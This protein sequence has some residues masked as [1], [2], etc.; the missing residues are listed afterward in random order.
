M[1]INRFSMIKR[2]L[3]LSIAAL[4]IA[5]GQERFTFYYE[6]DGTFVKPLYRTD[7]HYTDGAKFEFT[8]QPDVNF[9]KE[10]SK[11]DR[12][13]LNDGQV[14][15]AL[16]YFLGQNIYTP[17][18]TENPAERSD[19]DMK[20]AGW[21]YGGIFAQRQSDNRMEHLELNLGMIGPAASGES[22]QKFIHDI[23]HTDAPEGWESQLDNE[24][25]ADL[26][27][28]RRQRIPEL[29]KRTECLDTHLEYGGTLGTLHRN[30]QLGIV[31]RYGMNIPND[32]GPTRL[33]A[34]ASGCSGFPDTFESFYI[35]ARFSG[36]VVEFNR[37]LS[38][39]TPEPV[40]GEMH[41]GFA[42]RRKSFEIS[43]SQTFMTKEFEHQ[44]DSDS[45]GA[46][47]LLWHFK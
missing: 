41:F 16:G 15:T 3:I 35:F 8:H 40:V 44:E 18:H 11:W 46:I 6:N 42:Y 1:N 30:A 47:N 4:S 31:F 25:H 43:Y 36:R 32:F 34:P 20:Y 26:T 2:A 19:C 12:F 38:G 22:A 23:I 29:A 28:L 9:L 39:L 17:D 10:Y 24:F 33:A 13:C 27:L 37:F 21:L 14:N 7:R 5:S 45:F